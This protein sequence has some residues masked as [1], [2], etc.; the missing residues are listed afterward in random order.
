[1]RKLFKVL[2]RAVLI[3]GISLVMLEAALQAA[4]PQLPNWLIK[5][6]PQYQER[7]GWRLDTEHGAREW[8]AWKRETFEITREFGDLYT[9]TCLSPDAAPPFNS[10]S[11]AY[12]RDSH[13]YR[14]AEPWPDEVELAVLGD[15]FTAAEAIVRPF[16]QGLAGSI[17]AFGLPGSGSVEHSRLFEAFARPRN[18]QTVVLAFFAG[19]DLQDS[20]FYA[21]FRAKGLS[22]ADM[23]HEGEQPWDYL[24]LLNLVLRLRRA[25]A[26]DIKSDCH[27][28]QTALTNP[29]TP[30]A[31]LD[32]FL[33]S[34]TSDRKSLLSSKRYAL[35][36]AAIS[37]MAQASQ[38]L[39]ADMILM[40]IPQKAE[41]Y[42]P[43]LS[44]QS[45][46]AIISGVQRDRR[47]RNLDSIDQHLRV[48]R[49]VMRD[50]SAQLGIAFLDL[51]APLTAAAEAGQPPYF[52]ADTH[53]NQTGHDI[54]RNALLKHLN[55]TNLE[56]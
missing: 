50:L 55:Q 47:Y 35:A 43:Y 2:A 21:G 9:L 44:D 18:P 23:R 31:F 42:W 19:N 46:Q 32:G 48:L 28:P 49:D 3:A 51:T 6:M 54:A 56:S 30:V 10:Y 11:L 24:V 20:E 22:W 41:I 36:R 40:Y 33:T 29:P 39:D 26:P 37:E 13:G 45:K 12:Q 14:N 34:L 53:W 1:M 15:S 5:N 25:Q 52:F 27:F 4:F 17:L 38:A 8:P 16:W 7:L